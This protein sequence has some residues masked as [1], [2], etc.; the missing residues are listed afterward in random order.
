MVVRNDGG[1]SVDGADISYDGVKIATIDNPGA[2]PNDL[3]IAMLPTVA[4]TNERVLAILEAIG[5]ESSST[6]SGPRFTRFLVE[7]VDGV[8]STHA[9]KTVRAHEQLFDYAEVESV[10]FGGESQQRS[11]VNSITVGFDQVVEVQDGAFELRK[12]GADGGVVDIAISTQDVD[13]KTVATL[14]F[15][16]QFSEHS[17]LVDGNYELML[18]GDKIVGPHR[19]GADVDGDNMRGGVRRIGTVESDRFYRY[20]G[21]LDADRTV[22]FLDYTEFRNTFGDA[23][24]SDDFNEAFDF[25]ADGVIG[26][27]DFSEFRK[28]FGKS[29][30]F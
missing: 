27:V 21:D 29:L 1:I 20:F 10:Q 14:T 16:G 5:F 13:N 4:A 25:N 17:S 6:E 7:T 15:I 26:F 8:E 3:E 2:A 23:A 9:F 12:R 19:Q 11:L 18:V 24:G 22:G 30:D 28:R